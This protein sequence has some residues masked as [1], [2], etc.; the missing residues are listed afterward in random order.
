MCVC[1]V[2]VVVEGHPASTFGYWIR[3]LWFSR[4]FLH[5][6][7]NW[8]LLFKTFILGKVVEKS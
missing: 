4:T 3:T 7:G 2:V 5:L 1:V 8:V 6:I